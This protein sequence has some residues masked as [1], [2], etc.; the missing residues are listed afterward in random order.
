[1]EWR[2]DNLELPEGVKGELR[3]LY[4]GPGFPEGRDGGILAG[5][6]RAGDGVIWGRRW[7]RIGAVG[8]AA[9]VML[10]AGVWWNQ[11]ERA[12]QPVA[13][14]PAATYQRTGDIR[15]AFYVARAIAAHQ[16]L[17]ANWDVN[18]DGV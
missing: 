6:R 12:G 17:E 1:M 10:V 4:R 16:T 18:G 11:F 3:G 5:A 9:A 7:R 2:E 13:V 15:D 14:A 8:I